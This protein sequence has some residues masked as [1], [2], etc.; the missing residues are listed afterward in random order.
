M[1]NSLGNNS[2]NSSSIVEYSTLCST[3]I[4]KIPPGCIMPSNLETLHT[5]VLEI[6]KSIISCWTGCELDEIK[7]VKLNNVL[8]LIYFNPKCK[9]GPL[10]S[11][12]THI[13]STLKIREIASG[14]SYVVSTQEDNQCYLRDFNPLDY[15]SYITAS[16]LFSLLSSRMANEKDT[17]YKI[18]GE[19]FEN[20]KSYGEVVA[21][22]QEMGSNSSFVGDRLLF[23]RVTKKA[24]DNLIVP[25]LQMSGT[26]NSVINLTYAFY[27]ANYSKDYYPYYESCFNFSQERF[28]SHCLIQK[29]VSF[30]FKKALTTIH[31][32]SFNDTYAKNWSTQNSSTI[33]VELIKKWQDEIR[34]TSELPQPT[35]TI[36]LD[37]LLGFLP[38]TD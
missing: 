26:F 12:S 9:L 17:S 16:G 10:N 4:A 25:C 29:D 37:S 13:L 7:C 24:F 3:R 1:N 31:V 11:F 5:H 8:S 18:I 34:K 19:V 36:K 27:I 38:L 6:G 28:V 22:F 15:E 35:S 32:N 33:S 20:D 14:Y 2:S 21:R 23:R 30:E